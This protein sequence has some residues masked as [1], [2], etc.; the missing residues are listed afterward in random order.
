MI[1]RKCRICGLLEP[2][3]Q[4]LPKENLCRGCKREVNRS[5]YQLHREEHLIAA[6]E[7]YQENTAVYKVRSQRYYNEH[8]TGASE[9]QSTY[10][11]AN[12]EE[13]LRYGRTWRED[14]IEDVQRYAKE[15]REIHPEVY[16]R[17]KAKRR[18]LKLSA[19]KESV[20]DSAVFKRDRWICGICHEAIN[21]SLRHPDPMSASRDHIIPLS[22]GGEE[23]YTN[24]QAT[25]LR[26]NLK[27]H[28]R[29]E[30]LQ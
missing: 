6:R 8:R 12:R 7:H 4:L 3:V 13:R 20:N 18:A 15:Y 1:V 24:S 22:R 27:K 10:Y 25:H 9:W 2:E 11:R 29:I 5:Y 14:H 19:Y 17:G 30:V 16:R 28:N 23:S 26:C 21:P